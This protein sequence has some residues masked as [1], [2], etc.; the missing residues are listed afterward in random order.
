MSITFEIDKI[1]KQS[2]MS[3]I[4]NITKLLIV[5]ICFQALRLHRKNSYGTT[6]VWIKKKKLL[7][8]ID[9]DSPYDSVICKAWNEGGGFT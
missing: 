4:M 1:T 6:Y 2:Y 8:W 3:F 9:T 7:S 5:Y